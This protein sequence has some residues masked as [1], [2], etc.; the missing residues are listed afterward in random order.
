MFKKLSI[1][2]F[3]AIFTT[4]LFCQVETVKKRTLSTVEKTNEKI[5]GSF[6]MNYLKHYLWRGIVFGNDNVAQPLLELSYKNFT[7]GLSQNFN[8]VPK[9]VDRSIY[10]KDA[11]FDE[12]DIEIN[13]TKEWEN[14]S[15]DFSVLGYFY[16]Y[17]LRTPNTGEIKNKTTFSLN[18]GLSFFTENVVDIAAYKGGLYSNNGISYEYEKINKYA[19]ECTAY[20]SFANKIYNTNYF[21]T[22]N[23]SFNLIGANV[24]LRK[25]FAHFFIKLIGEKNIYINE[26]VKNTTQIKGNSNYGLAFG[27]KF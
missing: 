5:T 24:E 2:I 15:T 18:N 6:E 26:A 13:Y 7:F 12:Q 16:F 20:A 14:I 11:S 9:S 3:L 19:M 22:T 25:E 27:F 8:Y 21:G 10:T 4:N 23:G 1:F 17:Q